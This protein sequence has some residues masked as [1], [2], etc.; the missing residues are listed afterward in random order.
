M[1]LPYLVLFVGELQPM[2]AD[3][4]QELRY[5]M[6]WLSA[7]LSGRNASMQK[8]QTFLFKNHVFLLARYS[9]L[10]KQD[11]FTSSWY[12]SILTLFLFFQ[13]RSH[14]QNPHT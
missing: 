12:Q 10:K 14:S 4:G 6:D 7:I 5:T 1:M 3:F 2:Q 13:C 9:V 8:R 11:I